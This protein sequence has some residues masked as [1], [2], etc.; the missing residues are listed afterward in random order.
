MNKCILKYQL[1]CSSCEFKKLY[2]LYHIKETSDCEISLVNLAI[3]LCDRLSERAAKREIYNAFILLSQFPLTYYILAPK[4]YMQLCS[5]AIFA[6]IALGNFDDNVVHKILTYYEIALNFSK[7]NHNVTEEDYLTS[8]SDYYL[9]HFQVLQL[10]RKVK[11]YNEVDQIYQKI[12]SQYVELKKIHL[13]L[14]AQW[15]ASLY[16]LGKETKDN[17]LKNKSKSEIYSLFENLNIDKLTPFHY[18]TLAKLLEHYTEIGTFSSA[19]SGI[20]L[21]NNFLDKSLEDK[22]VLSLD[23]AVNKTIFHRDA[24]RA[25]KMIGDERCAQHL[26]LAKNISDEFC[27][28]DQ[29]IKI[30]K[31]ESEWQNTQL[32]KEKLKDRVFIFIRH[33]ST[34]NHYNCKKPYIFISYAHKN[35]ELIKNDILIFQK[36]KYNYWVDFENIDGGRNCRENDWTEKINPILDNPLCMGIIVY[37]SK[38]GMKSSKG[39]LFEAEWILKHEKDF[40]LFL[41]DFDNNIV[42]KQMADLIVNGINEIDPQYKIRISKAFGY[43]LQADL[44]DDRFSYYHCKD[45]SSHLKYNDFLK[46]IDKTIN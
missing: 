33:S 42:P 19:E 20:K 12:C 38:E 44:D 1:N 28:I 29:Q 24:Y 36:R 11:L 5:A 9:A 26:S 37:C 10:Q 32:K 39:A 43:I 41:I 22:Y 25:L 15:T 16:L 23:E 30:S 21:L 2:Q 4:L 17:K 18:F 27:L 8:R 7:K 34:K 46:W 40:F 45:D 3:A 13:R 31:I 35:K 6:N 14:H